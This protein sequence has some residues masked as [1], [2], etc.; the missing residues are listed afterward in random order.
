MRRLI[1]IIG[2]ALLF[3][4]FG[5]F[6]WLAFFKPTPVLVNKIE[7]PSGSPGEFPVSGPGAPVSPKGGEPPSTPPGPARFPEAHAVQRLVQSEIKEPI[8]NS[9]GASMI[10]WDSQDSRFWT[11]DGEGKRVML[12][13]KEFPDISQAV[14]S[15]DRSQAI[16]E[17]PDGANVLYNFSTKSQTTLPASWK[18]FSFSPEGGSIVFKSMGRE[19]ESRYLATAS[20][21]GSNFKV[22]TTLGDEDRTV[23]PTWSP[24]GQIA[25]MFVKYKANRQQLYFLGTNEEN[26]N[27]IPLPG[28]GFKPLWA[29]QG[30]RLAYQVYSAETDY[31]PSLWAVDASP[32]SLG[33]NRVNLNILTFIQKCAWNKTGSTMYCAVPRNLPEGAA[34]APQV[35]EN[36]PDDIWKIDPRTGIKTLIFSPE[37]DMAVEKLFISTDEQS[38]FVQDQQGHGLQTVKLK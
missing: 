26:F 32:D 10:L 1:F 15:P 23:F 2:L 31:R 4:L 9:D 14:F 38:L 28:I 35:A 21:D 36:E 12:S 37:E 20:P 18:D 30:E 3:A 19:M 5:V 22:I 16:I 27:S 24:Q 33:A 34:L 7:P 25:A 11:V 17:F 8:L 13:Q 6:L 29:P